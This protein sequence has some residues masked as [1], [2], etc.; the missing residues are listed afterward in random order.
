MFTSK[1]A[2]ALTLSTIVIAALVL[3]VLII[4]SVIFV[5]RM[6]RTSELSQDCQKRGG[7]CYDIANGATCQEQ[8]AGLASMAD[9]KCLKSG[10]NNQ[11]VEDTTKI[12][13]TRVG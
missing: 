2:E 7:V 13:C 6:A 5:G 1:K 10:S 12:C 3:L 8:D 4:L 9:A 11:K